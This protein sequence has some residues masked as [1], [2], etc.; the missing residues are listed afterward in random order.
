MLDCVGSTEADLL[1]EA[2]ALGRLTAALGAPASGLMVIGATARNILS[3]GLFGRLPRR[4]TRDVDIAVAVASWSAYERA[5]ATLRRRAGVHAFTVDVDG[6][7][8]PV[9]VVPYG[10]IEAVDRTVDLPDDHRLNV[11]GLREAFATAQTA[12]LPGDVQVRVPTVPGLTL[13]K[14]VA[15]SERHLL[16]R[17]DAVDLDEIIGWYAQGRFLDALYADVALLE[18]YDFDIELAAAHR[19]GSDV[20]AL[21]SPAA[22]VAIEALLGQD[23]RARLAGDMLRSATR[24]P[25]RLDALANGFGAEVAS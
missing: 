2:Q 3:V 16:H 19:L 10:G 7:H 8:V 20:S 25:H 21:L 9:D 24:H 13:L 18:L 17:R 6:V 12:R 23:R 11:L 22:H 1:L 5:T 15:W 4:G 14:L